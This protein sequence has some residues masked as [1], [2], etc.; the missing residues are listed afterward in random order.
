MALFA[1]NPSRVAAQFSDKVTT[2]PVFLQDGFGPAGDALPYDGL[3]Y[4]IPTSESMLL[5]YLG[6]NGFNQIGPSSPT[7]ADELN[8]TRVMAGLMR[9]DAIAGTGSN[10]GMASAIQVYLAAKGIST[11]D[12]TLTSLSSPTLSALAS[13]NQNQTVVDLSCGYYVPSGSTYTRTGGH[14]VALLSQGVNALGQS[15]PSTLVINNPCPSAF[16]PEAD[17]PSNALQ[18]VNTV[19]TTG[20]LTADGALELDPNQYPGF[21]G[22]ARDVVETAIALTVSTSQQSANHP[23]PATWTLPSTQTIYLQNGSLSVVAP[24]QGPGGITKGDGGLLELEA[25]DSTT[26]ANVVANGTLRSDVASGLPFGSGAIQLQAGTLQLTPAG[27]TADVSLTAANGAGNQL[28]FVNGATLALSRN[29][30][31]SLTFSIGGNTDGTTA[32][33]VRSPGST[34]TLV[35]APDGGTAGLGVAERV[36]VNGTSGNLP[37]L[38]NGIVAPYIVAA[39]S[40]GNGSGDFLTYGS[41]GFA[42]A[43]YTRASTTSITSA[44]TNAVFEAD[45]A[46]TVPSNTTAQVFALKVG[47]VTVGG[48]VSAR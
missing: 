33:L 41:G 20:S 26:G 36:I 40:D 35:I 14:G 9:T 29:G 15:A 38:S 8:L 42:K 31:N 2:T 16:A 47:P 5:S 27:G 30:D 21:W 23:T 17:I 48:G 1:G 39:D 13:L 11:S 32:N 4:C 6:I 7:T 45:V 19:P 12:Y 34:G 44:G 43:A 3:M 18:Y 10:P 37:G 28:T 22:S 24:L 46:Q 25:P